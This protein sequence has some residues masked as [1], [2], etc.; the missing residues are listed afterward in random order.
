[1]VL[2]EGIVTFAQDVFSYIDAL[3]SFEFP[4]STKSIGQ[5]VLYQ[6]SGL[7]SI[8]VKAVDVP[9][10][11]SLMFDGSNCPIYVPEESVDAYKEA[12]YWSN[13]KNRIMPIL[14]EG[15][16]PSVSD[17]VSARFLG[18]S[19]TV[20]NGLIKYNSKLNYG[21]YNNS[22]KSIKVLT[23]QLIDGETGAAGNMMSVNST[24]EAGSSAAW[25]ITIGLNGIHSPQAV[26]VYS[27][28]GKR[29][30]IRVPYP[31]SF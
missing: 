15:D 17:N 30:E 19:V 26:F 23:I 20:V 27:C 9:T 31:K 24:I 7:A 29:Y 11:S 21:V 25:T 8:T 4:A 6:C 14:A 5:G 28:E 2:P 3:T 22:G 1:V 10:G 16:D 13:Y 12:N 18:G